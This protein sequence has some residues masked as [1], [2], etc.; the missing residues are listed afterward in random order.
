[1]IRSASGYGSGRSRTALTTL[2][3]AVFAPMPS[4]SVRMAMNANPGDL[5]SWRRAIRMS[6]NM[7]ISFGSQRDD[8][9]YTCSAAGW[10]TA[11]DQCDASEDKS[12]AEK[13]RKI[14]GA[15]IV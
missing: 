6:F 3:I 14:P 1:M 9:I 2:K 15:Q 12:C 8:G 11:G 5:R 13:T 10:H 7:E 4:A